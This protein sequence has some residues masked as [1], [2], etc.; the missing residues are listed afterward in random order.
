MAET[1][2]ECGQTKPL[3]V[4]YQCWGCNRV[5]VPRGVAPP[6]RREDYRWAEYLCSH[7]DCPANA[8]G[9]LGRKVRQ[10]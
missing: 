8:I 2:G 4:A 7:P 9:T 3:P 5:R 10:T 6:I 1:C